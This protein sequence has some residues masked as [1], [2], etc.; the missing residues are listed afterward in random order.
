MNGTLPREVDR[1]PID[2]KGVHTN[3][4]PPGPGPLVVQRAAAA[5]GIREAV[6]EIVEADAAVPCGAGARSARL[7]LGPNQPDQCFSSNVYNKR[8]ELM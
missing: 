3:D 2:G 5:A 1:L 8:F 6:L 4:L 7:G